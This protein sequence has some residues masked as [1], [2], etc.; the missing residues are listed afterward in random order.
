MREVLYISDLIL[1]Q[2]LKEDISLAN[3][4]GHFNL[5]TTWLNA[6]MEDKDY[7]AILAAYAP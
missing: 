5:L 4:T 2:W 3:K 1:R 7:K 6:E